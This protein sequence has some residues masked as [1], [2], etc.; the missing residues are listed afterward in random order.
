MNAHKK[1]ETKMN[2][3]WKGCR[4]CRFSSIVACN[5]NCLKT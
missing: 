2:K 5:Y 3:N 4:F 1:S